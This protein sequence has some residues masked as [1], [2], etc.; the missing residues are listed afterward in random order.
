MVRVLLPLLL[1]PASAVAAPPLPL[2]GV[3]VELRCEVEPRTEEALAV[4]GGRWAADATDAL[5][6]RFG[7][8]LEAAGAHPALTLAGATRLGLSVVL[9][10]VEVEDHRFVDQR[11]GGSIVGLPMAHWVVAA[12]VDVR[13]RLLGPGAWEL[14]VHQQLRRGIAE[15]EGEPG[16]DREV[17]LDRALAASVAG[18]ARALVEGGPLREGLV[19]QV[20]ACGELDF[21]PLDVS[22]DGRDVLLSRDLVTR[23][24]ALAMTLASD[25]VPLPVRIELG[26]ATILW[27]PAAEIR[28]DAL[29]WWLARPD[30]QGGDDD[31]PG[32]TAAVLRAVLERDPAP[33]VRAVAARS[34]L[35]RGDPW[36]VALLRLAGADPDP[37]VSEL[38]LGVLR[39]GPS[40]SVPADLPEAAV[41]EGWASALWHRCLGE[42]SDHGAALERFALETP[43]FVAERWWER[44]LRSAAVPQVGWEALLGH[45]SRAVRWALL[46]RMKAPVAAEERAAILDSILVSESDPSL[47]AL[48]LERAGGLPEAGAFATRARQDPAAEVRRAA[49]NILATL[50]DP[51][52]EQPLAELAADPDPRVRRV[53]RAALRR[54]K[55]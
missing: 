47:R 43:G 37:S 38:A 52:V 2:D 8:W 46:D 35:R 18:L 29:H 31:L 39:A 6:A 30:L 23:H 44:R 20:A 22:A 54:R 51:G 25:R 7:Q 53:A 16:L 49:A 32:R 3:P 12:D 55:G 21:G 9:R 27:D 17:L 15:Q 11:L 26:L 10:A 14:P 28:R 33:S 4:V 42:T 36:S 19:P 41:P 48:A 40:P 45:P 5:C 24:D 34:L 13:A 50:S 1:L